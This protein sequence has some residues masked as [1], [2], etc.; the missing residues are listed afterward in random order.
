HL[1]RGASALTL[2]ESMAWTGADD[3]LVAAPESR[4]VNGVLAPC[5]FNSRICIEYFGWRCWPSRLRPV[6]AWIQASSQAIAGRGMRT[7]RARRR[8][9]EHPR[10]LRVSPSRATGFSTTGRLAAFRPKA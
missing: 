9:P 7:A 5:R 1:A 10:P 2:G 8:W 3:L 6:A 4:F